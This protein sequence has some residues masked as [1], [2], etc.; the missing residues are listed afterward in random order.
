MS[1][2]PLTATAS[3][4][5]VEVATSYSKSVLRAVCG[6]ISDH[7]ADVDYFPS[8]EII[9]SLNSR[10]VYFE[11]NQRSVSV[12][13]VQTAMNMFLQAHGLNNSPEQNNTDSKKAK[14]FASNLSSPNSHE[15]LVCEEQL[16]E[17]FS[18]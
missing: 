17:S 14:S 8:Y 15:D 5:H 6:T 9:T 7:Y 11:N 10:G 3:G 13:G 16:L 12:T 4:Q 18:Q 1:P 2:V